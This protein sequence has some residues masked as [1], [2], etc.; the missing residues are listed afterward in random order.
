[1]AQHFSERLISSLAPPLAAS[2]IHLIGVF[3]RIDWVGKEIPQ[4]CW[5]SGNRVIFSFWHEQLLLMQKSI[6]T[7]AKVLISAS[8][9][10]ELIARTVSRF[11]LGTI[12][13][14]S[15]RGGMKAFRALLKE[16]QNPVDFA[17]T[18]DGPKGPRRQ[19]KEGVAQLARLTG[20]PVIPIAFACSRGH[21]FRSWD[22]F[23]LPFPWGRAVFVFGEGVRAEKDEAL[24]DFQRRLQHAMDAANQSAE[25]YL[26]AKGVSAV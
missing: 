5:D 9:D 18:P 12:R 14:S 4:S 6:R 10:G 23:L 3:L 26:E 8:K 19:M 15:T 21:R 2:I 7:E 1:M 22:R 11:G 13:G 24:D 17:V 20:R 16:A 25:Q